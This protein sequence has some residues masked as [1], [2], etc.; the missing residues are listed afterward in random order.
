LAGAVSLAAVLGILAMEKDAP[1]SSPA[2]TQANLRALPHKLVVLPFRS[3]GTADRDLMLELGMAETLIT[4]L[5]RSTRLDVL[6]LGSVQPFA[7]QSFDP[8]ATA[9]ALGADYVLDGSTQRNGDLVRVNA[10]LLSLRDGRSLWSGTFDAHPDRVFTL[11]DALAIGVSGALSLQHPGATGY[12]SPCDGEDAVA[13]RAYLRGRHLM[14]RPD[15]VRLPKALA[16]F[17]EALARDP[18][19]ARAW[20]GKAFAYRSFAMAG[21]VDPRTAFP[22]ARNAV[23]HALRIDPA[24]AEAYATK[25][26]IEFWYD[27]DWAAAEASLRHAISLDPNLAE[28][29]YAL[30]HLLHNIGRNGE[31]L[32][33][34]QRAAM[35]NPLSPIINTIV[36]SFH[37]TA[38][39][40]DEARRRLDAVLDLDPDFWTALFWRANL[41]ARK[42]N[43]KG[44]IADMQRANVACARC[45]HALAG[46]A[47]LQA[48]AGNAAQAQELLR[49]MQRRDAQGYFPATR[50]ALAHEA[51]GQRKQALDMLE[52]AHAERDLYL[53]FLLVDQRLRPLIPEP[54]FQA[55]VRRLRLDDGSGSTA[56]APR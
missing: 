49:E 8:M 30:A 55:L 44:A 43:L 51:L 23:R 9:R 56:T 46:L 48:K 7:G 32:P 12:R 17:D 24:S 27:W 25:G 28:A 19:C 26:V 1:Q 54:R 6:S 36:A 29:H 38:G 39:R 52:R 11:Q 45:S 22:Q 5:S 41:E 40:D 21:D 3:I 14:F 35:L 4:R 15:A 53:T 47:W 18:G 31:G 2:P 37:V 42:G 50:L 34:A 33:H 13:Y 16:A 20:A 10:R